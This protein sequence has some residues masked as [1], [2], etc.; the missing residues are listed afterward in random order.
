MFAGLAGVQSGLAQEPSATATVTPAVGPA[1]A[2]TAAMILPAESVGPDDLLEIMVPYCPELSRTFRISSDGSLALP[3]LKHPL[4]VAGLLPSVVAARVKEALEQEQVLNDPVV[5]ISVLEYR[6]RP[7]SVIGAVT[8]PQTF[9]AIGETT[10]LDAIARAG[11]LTP[12][13]G[14][15]ILVTS[16]RLDAQGK[17]QRT[18]ASIPT[19]SL[20]ATADPAVNLRLHGGEEIRVP[21]AG[22]IFVAGNVRHPGMYLM[23]SDAETTVVKALALSEGLQPYSSNTAYIYRRQK[24]GDERLEVKVALSRII[25]RKDPDVALLADDILYVPENGGKKMTSKVL[26]QIAGF[27]QT[28]ATGMLI[29][30]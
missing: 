15:A 29:Y 19:N 27:G 30:H 5:T 20:V 6:S 21:E 23:Q 22:K 2:T 24:A 11:G 26:N 12:S 8:H 1:G 10:L 13:A 9:Q 17:L 16:Q 7:V 28:T 14:A 25:A 18:V 3:L 4:A